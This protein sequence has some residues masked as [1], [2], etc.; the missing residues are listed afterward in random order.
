MFTAAI[1]PFD[2]RKVTWLHQNNLLN[3]AHETAT[4]QITR[5][6]NCQ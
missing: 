6:T 2:L 3:D 5:L 1:L 4:L